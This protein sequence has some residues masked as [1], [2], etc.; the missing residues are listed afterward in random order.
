LPVTLTALEPTIDA[1]ERPVLDW[2][3]DWSADGALFGY[4]VAD[5]PGASWG[6]LVVVAVEP[7]TGNLAPESE[8]LLPPT[9]ARRSFTL[10]V[11]SV[12]WVAPVDGQVDGEV[13]IRTWGPG[14]EGGR[15]MPIVDLREVMPAF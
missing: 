9:L 10:G 13:R 3:V 4:W 2:Q 14:G 7:L 1:R 12:A 5:A 15:S 6:Q 8:P 11:N